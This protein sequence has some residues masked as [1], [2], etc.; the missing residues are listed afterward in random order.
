MLL[1]PDENI[2]SHATSFIPERWY[3]NPE[4]VK[5]VGAFAPFSAGMYIP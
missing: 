2:Y 3:A 5:E 1:S 4:M